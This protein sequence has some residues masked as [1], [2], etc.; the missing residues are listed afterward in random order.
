MQTYRRLEN[1]SAFPVHVPT[2]FANPESP[3]EAAAEVRAESPARVSSIDDRESRR[4]M[5]V[6]LDAS[7]PM[8]QRCDLAR[9]SAWLWSATCPVL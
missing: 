6:N 7:W 1:A 5:T 8:W 3:S 9:D 4:L 2:L